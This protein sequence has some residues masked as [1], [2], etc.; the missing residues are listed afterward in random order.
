MTKQKAAL[1]ASCTTHGVQDGLSSAIYVLLPI[2]AQSFGLNYGQVGLFKATKS[3]TQSVLEVSSGFATERFGERHI[4][5]GA[6]LMSGLGYLLLSFATTPN[7]MLFCFVILGVGGAYHHA[8][9]SALVTHSYAINKRR[10]ALGFYNSSGDA[11][12]L[13]FTALISLA[14]I[15]SVTWQ[16]V[17]FGYGLITLGF[18]GAVYWVLSRSGLGRGDHHISKNRSNQKLGW[19]ILDRPKFTALLTTVLMD[20]MVQAGVLTFVAFAMIAKDV[21][22]YAATFASVLVLIGGMLGKAVCGF[23]ADRIGMRLAFTLLQTLTAL[24]LVLLVLASSTTAFILLPFLGVAVQGTSSIT[25]VLV[26]DLIHV[27]RTARGY[28]LI[29]TASSLASVVGPLGFGLIGDQYGIETAMLAMAVVAVIAI[30]PCILL[31]M[32]R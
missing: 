14:T 7:L 28:S 6:L 24:G 23:M 17:A 29:Y 18:A 16:T 27:D 26:N 3:L 25:Y 15:V 20:S 2:L 21:P 22:V 5:T 31:K 4:L 1:F 8:P 30:L 13:A 32:P 12:K 9:S 19:G 11:G 10:R